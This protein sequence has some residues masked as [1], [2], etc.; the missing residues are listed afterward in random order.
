MNIDA[1]R[2]VIDWLATQDPDEWHCVA[3]SWNWDRG[4]QP[5][6]WIIRQEACDRATALLVFWRTDPSY[7]LPYGHRDDVPDPNK[8]TYDLL[9]EIRANWIKGQYRRS[10]IAYDP[11]ADGFARSMDAER[12]SLGDDLKF[13]FPRDMESAQPGRSLDT[14]QYRDGLPPE[15]ADRIWG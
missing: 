14:S 8:E 6:Q 15:I 4:H 2:R 10:E 13:I 9:C 5:L 7:Y 1:S 3:A 11:S 12:A